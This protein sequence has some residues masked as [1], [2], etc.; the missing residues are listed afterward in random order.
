[1]RWY[2]TG[3]WINGSIKLGKF[4]FAYWNWGKY[5]ELQWSKNRIALYKF[6]W[7]KPLNSPN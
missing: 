5:I 6:K 1:M 4:R 2:S 7:M 3:N